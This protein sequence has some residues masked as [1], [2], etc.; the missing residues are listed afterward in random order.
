[1][2]L[3]QS[4]IVNCDADWGLGLT[5]KDA[6]LEIKCLRHKNDLERE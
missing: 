6:A 5:R 2:S 1:M 3:K 4:R